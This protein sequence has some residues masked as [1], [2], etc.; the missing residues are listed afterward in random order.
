MRIKANQPVGLFPDAA[1]AH[2]SS[3]HHEILRQISRC[4]LMFHWLVRAGTSAIAIHGRFEGEL[5]VAR[6]SAEFRDRYSLLHRAM[7]GIVVESAG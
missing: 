5:M 3:F 2:V 4:R 1:V 7:A 6:S